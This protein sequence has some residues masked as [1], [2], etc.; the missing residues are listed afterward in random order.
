MAAVGAHFRGLTG[1][2]LEEICDADWDG[3]T[4]AALELATREAHLDRAHAHHVSC[5]TTEIDPDTLAMIDQLEDLLYCD[6]T[7]S[8][9]KREAI[10]RA[11]RVEKFDLANVVSRKRLA[12][13]YLAEAQSKRDGALRVF[14]ALGDPISRNGG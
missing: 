1:R 14:V 12:L 9:T 2:R 11:F 6:D 4:R 3:A 7:L 13:R 10:R 5:Q 8:D